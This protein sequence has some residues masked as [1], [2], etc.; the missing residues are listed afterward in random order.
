MDVAMSTW[1]GASLTFLGSCLALTLGLI[2]VLSR[3]KKSA[4]GNLALI[5]SRGSA[6]ES[7]NPAG[8]V[9]ID[10]ELWPAISAR[11]EE[12][13]AGEVVEVTGVTG[14]RLVVRINAAS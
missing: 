2:I 5:G 6:H 8:F 1:I 4:M 7:L 13:L 14:I 9:A 12:I 11:R 10:G 3:H